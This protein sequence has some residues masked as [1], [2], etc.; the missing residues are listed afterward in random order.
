MTRTKR[1]YRSEIAD[2]V[3]GIEFSPREWISAHAFTLKTDRKFTKQEVTALYLTMYNRLDSEDWPYHRYEQLN[4]KEMRDIV[5]GLMY[6]GH[7][8]FS[9]ESTEPLRERKIG[10]NGSPFTKRELKMIA[11][12]LDRHDG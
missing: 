8:A 12:V 7:P 3:N 2:E 1:D 9:F 11:H 10:D 6:V 4:A 5:R